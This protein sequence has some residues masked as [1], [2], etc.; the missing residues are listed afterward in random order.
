[1]TFN[2]KKLFFIIL[3]VIFIANLIVF[4]IN[5]LALAA[6]YVG[7]HILLREHVSGKYSMNLQEYHTFILSKNVSTI[8]CEIKLDCGHGSCIQDPNNPNNPAIRICECDDRYITSEKG[9][10]DEM[11]P[12]NYEQRPQLITLI[13]SWF[14][15]FLGI[16]WFYLARGNLLYIFVGILKIFLA[17]A[18]LGIWV[19][20]DF[21]RILF[22]AFPDGNGVKL[23]PF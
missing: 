14:G 4:F 19:L 8:P 15:G 23:W 3:S 6:F 18:T 16:D 10:D 9:N 7:K 12:C 11:G 22:N 1:M 21:F 17:E 5:G 2:K 20:I 13:I